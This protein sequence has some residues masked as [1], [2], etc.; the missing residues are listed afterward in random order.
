MCG[1]LWVAKLTWHCEIWQ[2]RRSS[3][4]QD[5]HALHIHLSALMLASAQHLHINLADHGTGVQRMNE[6]ATLATMVQANC[7][8]HLHRLRGARSS[9]QSEPSPD[10]HEHYFRLNRKGTAQDTQMA[11]TVHYTIMVNSYIRHVCL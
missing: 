2:R 7:C 3:A 11:S 8:I 1:Q 10:W 6:C 4:W 9:L 5:E